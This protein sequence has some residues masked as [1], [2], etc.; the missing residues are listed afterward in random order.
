MHWPTQPVKVSSSD[1]IKVPQKL[2]KASSVD[3][4]KTII[5]HFEVTEGQAASVC[6]RTAKHA[7]SV[8]QR[9]ADGMQMAGYRITWD[10]CEK[11]IKI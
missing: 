5:D 6:H 2:P 3:V 10:I 9:I 8:W 4:A 1:I 11:N 7:K